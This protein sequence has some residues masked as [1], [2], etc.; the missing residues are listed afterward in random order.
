MMNLLYLGT[1]FG[2]PL[3]YLTYLSIKES[4][5]SGILARRRVA[6]LAQIREA[7]LR[8]AWEEK[9]RRQARALE[10]WR[11]NRALPEKISA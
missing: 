8:Q 3:A 10:E 5:V 4:Q 2:L 6:R 11:Q 9:G 7:R 1:V